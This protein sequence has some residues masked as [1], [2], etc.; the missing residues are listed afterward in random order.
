[1]RVLADVHDGG[2]QYV[3]TSERVEWR[4]MHGGQNDVHAAW[5]TGRRQCTLDDEGACWQYMNDVDAEWTGR[6][7][8]LEATSVFVVDAWC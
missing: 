8:C 6:F 7:Q 2:L 1:M 3:T 4:G 5:I